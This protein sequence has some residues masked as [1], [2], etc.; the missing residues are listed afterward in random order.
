MLA[1]QSFKSMNL[2]QYDP[3][4]VSV[5]CTASNVFCVSRQV[6]NCPLWHMAWTFWANNRTV[7]NL[8]AKVM[9]TCIILY[10]CECV[11]KY[12]Y[13]YTQ[14]IVKQNVVSRICFLNSQQIIVKQHVYTQIVPLLKAEGQNG[15]CWYV[16]VCCAGY[17]NN[18]C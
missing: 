1:S 9:Y 4:L 18:A 16:G 6:C 10:V 2:K 14:M 7:L 11:L 15:G 12:M 13:L 5:K 17:A 8:E 3:C